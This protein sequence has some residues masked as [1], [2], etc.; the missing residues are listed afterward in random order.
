MK[1]IYRGTLVKLLLIRTKRPPKLRN[2]PCQEP[3]LLSTFSTVDAHKALQSFFIINRDQVLHRKVIR[4]ASKNIRISIFPLSS[5]TQTEYFAF[6]KINF[7]T[8]Q[9]LKQT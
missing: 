5:T 3:S 8:R 7:E 1:S 6:V 9:L 4:R 2:L